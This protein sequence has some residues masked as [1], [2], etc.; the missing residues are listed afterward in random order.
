MVGIGTA[1]ADDPQLTA[2]DK[3]GAPLDRQPLRIVVDSRCRTPPN[4]RMMTE[5]GRTLVATTRANTAAAAA[6][7][8]VGAAVVQLPRQRRSR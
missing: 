7:E 4:A 3:R 5:P 1:L 6:L 8:N 2:R